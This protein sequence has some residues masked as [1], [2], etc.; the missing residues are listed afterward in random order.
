[1][2]KPVWLPASR[3]ASPPTPRDKELERLKKANARLEKR[4]YVAEQLVDLQKSL[5]PVRQRQRRQQIV[6]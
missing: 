5:A 1:M 2:A 4:A 6:S 3:G